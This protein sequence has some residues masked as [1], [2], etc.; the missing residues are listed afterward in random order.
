M[1]K[2]WIHLFWLR[3]SLVYVNPSREGLV[4]IFLV[5]DIFWITKYRNNQPGLS[6]SA[7][8]LEGGCLVISLVISTDFT[9]RDGGFLHQ[10][11]QSKL[12]G[13]GVIMLH[14]ESMTDESN[15]LRKCYC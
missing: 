3:G 6:V 4:A 13:V 8:C 2:E 15:N 12:H 5:A 1:C 7:L 9:D 11:E 14:R 10:C